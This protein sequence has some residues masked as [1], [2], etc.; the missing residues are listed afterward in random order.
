[1]YF[2]L[3]TPSCIQ[4]T[5]LSLYFFDGCNNLHT[6]LIRIVSQ[7]RFFFQNQNL[8]SADRLVLFSK[9]VIKLWLLLS[10]FLL[11]FNDL[12][13]ILTRIFSQTWTYFQNLNGTIIAW[14]VTILVCAIEFSR[15]TE[16]DDSLCL[17]FLGGGRILTDLYMA[18]NQK[19]L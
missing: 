15:K 16:Q 19:E 14:R 8:K 17:F 7:L 11:D 10:Q 5:V 2:I 13:V 1:M 3:C 12:H 6:I 4:K 9:Y 18:V